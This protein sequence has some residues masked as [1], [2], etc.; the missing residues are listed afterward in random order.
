M[1]DLV[2]HLASGCVLSVPFRDRQ[3][4][5]L[6]FY[7]GVLLPDVATRSVSILLER[8]CG[9]TY[10]IV[11]PMH[12]PVG[13]AVL[14]GILALLWWR[15]SERRVVFGGL[16]LGGLLHFLFDAFQMH[17][18]VGYFWA[19]PFTWKTYGWGLFYTESSIDWIPLTGTI[20]VA[21]Q[22]FTAWSARRRRDDPSPQP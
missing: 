15:P 14:A 9:S 2:A 6:W 16:L 4:F 5:R 13:Y 18:G 21:V 10:R 1:P 19:F 12:T 20:V 17:T 7:A 22:A 3:T 8:L 11:M